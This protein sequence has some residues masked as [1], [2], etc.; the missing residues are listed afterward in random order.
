[1]SL[2]QFK[3]LQKPS[4]T[5]GDQRAT[6]F[7]LDNPV[8]HQHALEALEASDMLLAHANLDLKEV[9]TIDRMFDFPLIILSFNA[10][11][12]NNV[13]AVALKLN[14]YSSALTRMNADSKKTFRSNSRM[15][16][17]NTGWERPWF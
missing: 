11:L 5:M 14:A 7:L 8:V 15:V 4:G 17:G 12:A 1:M 9:H 13:K 6:M 16:D 2:F 3:I 10:W